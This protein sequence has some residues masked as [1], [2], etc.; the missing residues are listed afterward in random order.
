[1]LIR[2]TTDDEL[3]GVRRVLNAG[4]LRVPAGLTEATTIIA[5]ANSPPILGAL[6]LEGPTITAIAVRPRR[7]GQGIG[8]ALVEA[9]AER[10]VRLVVQ[11]DP[12]VRPFWAGLG[13]TIQPA[14]GD[15][16]QRLRGVRA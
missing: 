2:E 12:S 14:V 4:A 6:V 1:M 7:R 16:R 11:F 5:L 3:L 13:F 15:T 9:A 10:R 8:T